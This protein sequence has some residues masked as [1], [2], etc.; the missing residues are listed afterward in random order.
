MTKTSTGF[1]DAD[2]EDGLDPLDRPVWGVE[3]ISKVIKRTPRQT[4]HLLAAGHL[5]GKNIARRW[6][7]TP[8][9]LLAA[10]GAQV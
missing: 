6:V 7:S 5:P 4:Q 9:Q 1:A 10:V 3:N 8:R 2:F